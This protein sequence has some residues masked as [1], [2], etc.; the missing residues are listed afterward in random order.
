MNRAA[1]IVNL[2]WAYEN[3]ITGR[4][5]TVAILDTG[6]TKHPDFMN[7]SNRIVAFQD[8]L[9]ERKVPYDDNGHGT[10]V[11]GILGGSGKS[12]DGLYMGVAPECHLVVVKVLDRKGNGSIADVIKGLKWVEENRKRY[13]IRVLNISVG[14]PI[15]KELDE[16]SQLVQAVNVLWDSGII[17]VAAA[18]NNG[19]VPGSIGSPGNSR[20]IITVGA[21]DDDTFV[22]MDGSKIKD[23]SS[24]GPTKECIIKPDIVAPGSNIVSCNGMKPGKNNMYSIKSGTSMATPLVSGAVALLLSKYPCM[25]GRDVKVRLKNSAD[26]MGLPINQQGWGRLNIKRLLRLDE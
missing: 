7:R 6:I 10:H 1:Q 26:D 17:V 15:E 23:Y 5:I 14:T 18:G 9:H 25:N 12:S 8:M 4:N 13:N 24:R 19:P 2:K 3:D 16:K 22:E 11:S 21:S 20:K